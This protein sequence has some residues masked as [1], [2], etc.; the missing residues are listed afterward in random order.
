MLPVRYLAIERIDFP[1]VAYFRRDY[2]AE[3]VGTLMNRLGTANEGVLLPESLAAELGLGI[4][5]PLALNITPVRDMR[6][7]LD[8]RVA[9]F[10]EHFPT[11]YPSD[12][13]V[14]VGNL[15]YL[16]LNAWDVLPYQVWLRV[17]PG[18][19]TAEV[20]DDVRRM[21]IK[22]HAEQDLTR[23][24]TDE[25]QN[26]ER[27]GI[28]G[29]LSI[30]FLAGAVLSVADLLVHSTFMLRERTMVH[31]VLGALGVPRSKILNMVI[32]EEITSVV[33]GLAMGIVC[34]IAGA[35][36]YVPFYRLGATGVPQTGTPVPPFTPVID[37]ARTDTMA[38]AVAVALLLAE[39]LLLLQMTRSRIFEVLRMGQHV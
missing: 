33:Y 17:A 20:L 5:D 11:M 16:D 13:P 30:C 32:L 36:L 26:L 8:L 37:W 4:G 38:L 10:F 31:A 6:L 3:S 15:D 2:A 14:I 25:S 7:R 19:D 39:A 34:G 12:A 18:A 27:T 23:A 35:M 29:L 1:Q 9:G 21:G 22:I 28:F 24:L